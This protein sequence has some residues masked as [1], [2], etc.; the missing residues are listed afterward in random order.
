MARTGRPALSTPQE[1]E[2]VF[3]L[4]DAGLSSREVAVAVYATP[5]LKDRV[6]R[7]LERRRRKTVR[8]LYLE[9]ATDEELAALLD[10]FEAV[11]LE[12]LGFLLQEA[13]ARLD[14]LDDLER[15]GG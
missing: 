10:A 7:L 9:E 3:A 12:D 8:G 6:L 11:P 14:D 1:R 4:T 2:R 13:H 15:E 5:A